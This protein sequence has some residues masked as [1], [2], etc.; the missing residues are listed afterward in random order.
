M[1]TKH[2]L[3]LL[4][5]ALMGCKSTTVDW[6][7]SGVVHITDNRLFMNTSASITYEVTSNGVRK[8]TFDG[9]SR[10]D[11]DALGAV[12]KGVAEGLK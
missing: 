6:L 9:A 11:S 4:A 10:G 5:L 3:L 7:P 12:A 2:Y 1:K 8:V